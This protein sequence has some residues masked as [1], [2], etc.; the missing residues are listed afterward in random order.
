MW[1]PMRCHGGGSAVYWLGFLGALVYYIQTA[2]SIWAGIVGIV[3]AFFW[4]AFLA[5]G[6]LKYLGM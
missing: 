4:P 2:T 6:A 5:Y 1:G 3:K